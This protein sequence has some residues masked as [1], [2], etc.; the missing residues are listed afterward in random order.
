MSRVAALVCL[1]AA[2]QESTTIRVE[3]RLVEVNAAV[4]DRKG[5]PVSD[6]KKE[7]FNVTENGVPQRIEFFGRSTQKRRTPLPD[8]PRG[9]VSNRTGVSGGATI[10]LVDAVNTPPLYRD[11]AAAQLQAFV[12]AMVKRDRLAIYV[13]GRELISVVDFT[14]DADTLNKT[15]AAYRAERADSR[16]DVIKAE[17]RL[18]E[19]SMPALIA[20]AAAMS[21]RLME[22]EKFSIEANHIDATL[23]TLRVI[24]RRVSGM[25]GRKNLLWFTAGIPLPFKG[26]TYTAEFNRA[27]NELNDA[28]VVV[29]PAEVHRL[30][31]FTE[32]TDLSARTTTVRRVA[33]R[34]GGT[35]VE[36][37][38][39]EAGGGQLLADEDASYTLG[40]YPSDASMDG[41]W[42]K[43]EVQVDRPRVDVRHREGYFAGSGATDASESADAHFAAA[44]RSPL[45]AT[46][47]GVDAWMEGTA[48]GVAKVVVR[49]HG[50][51]LASEV[52]E[53]KI[54]CPLEVAFVQT[55]AG[56]NQLDGIRDRVP[57]VF[58]REAM[59]QVIAGGVEYRKGLTRK[60]G[61]VFLRV[62]VRSQLDGAIGSVKM[63]W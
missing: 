24:A 51:D 55:D 58:T 15:L 60:P 56:G 48:N 29:Y 13:Q 6:L 36:A 19:D 25:P 35:I 14:T 22:R 12:N 27:M 28:G 16:D 18:L 21:T 37:D 41:R 4:R 3:T 45:D 9:A 50:T 52:R 8:L 10:I 43:I 1:A 32:P 62:L 40:Y 2:A 61:A 46:G 33:A 47:I 7:D 34:T 26:R 54:S 59:R 63:T 17:Q 23:N 42:R 44:L 57:L 30:M 31:Q 53:G 5:L 39:L 20:G 11:R 38:N 49:L